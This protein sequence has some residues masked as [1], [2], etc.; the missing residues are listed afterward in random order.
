MTT[1]TQEIGFLKP[2][3]AAVALCD[4]FK[5]I[6]VKTAEDYTEAEAKRKHAR[7]FKAALILAY[8]THPTVVAAKEIQVQ[9][10]ALEDRLDA[11][12]KDVKSGPMAK[13]EAEQERIRQ[14]EERRLAEIAR[15]AQEAETARLVAEQKAAW[16]KAEK[17]RKAAEAVAAKTKDAAKRKQAE[18]AARQA[19]ERAEQAKQ[20]AAAIKQDAAMAPPPVI[21]VE[22][23][24]PA[25]SRR[26]VYKWR[27]TVKDGR[28]FIKADMTTST[29]I[30][31]TEITGLPAHLFILSPVLLND[32]VDNQGEAAAIAGT[33]EVASEM[34]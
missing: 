18:E 27:L 13:Y 2:L 3:E 19:A 26:K 5:S 29:R 22:R 14:A 21:V 20:D 25:V 31:A 9:K 17:E 12:N 15:K 23:S 8:N 6:V 11:F 32:F 33:L 24:T 1:Q 16:D 7:D 34:V 4:S 28:Q 30:K 10:K